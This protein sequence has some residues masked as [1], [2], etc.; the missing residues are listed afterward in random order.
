MGPSVERL[1]QVQESDMSRSYGPVDCSTHPSIGTNAFWRSE[2]ESHF[3]GRFA[4]NLA[5]NRPTIEQIVIGRQ[6]LGLAR[7]SLYGSRLVCAF[8]KAPVTCPRTNQGLNSISNAASSKDRTM[9]M[10]TSFHWRSRPRDLRGHNVWH[11]HLIPGADRIICF[12]PVGGG[13]TGKSPSE[14]LVNV[15]YVTSHKIR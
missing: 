2:R 6:L 9:A 11:V 10:D 12:L 5:Y 15:I 7:S 3:Y 14:D 1:C 4:S 13:W 8:L